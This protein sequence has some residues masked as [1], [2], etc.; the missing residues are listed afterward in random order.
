[1]GLICSCVSKSVPYRLTSNAPVTTLT[2]VRGHH[3]DAYQIRD[4]DLIYEVSSYCYNSRRIDIDV[5]NV[6][7]SEQRI[8][9]EELKVDIS[10]MKRARVAIQFIYQ[11]LTPADGIE[12][13]IEP[14]L[15]RFAL[16]EHS[17]LKNQWAEPGHFSEHMIGPEANYAHILTVQLP[18][19]S[20][21]VYELKFESAGWQCDR[22][23][24][25]LKLFR[26]L[27]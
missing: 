3:Y 5:T 27:H 17:K 15:Q 2:G 9:F 26:R 6:G 8:N 16:M 1:M 7:T 24:N 13:R 14:P 19:P 12:R 10:N 21:Q 22:G 4:G 11:Y 20:G 25:P 23:F 18:V